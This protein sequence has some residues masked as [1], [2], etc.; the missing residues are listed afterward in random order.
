MGMASN[1]Y[2][3][4]SKNYDDVK[5]GQGYHKKTTNQ[6]IFLI[7]MHTTIQEGGGGGGGEG[8]RRRRRR[9]RNVQELVLGISP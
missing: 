9:V 7:N 6:S 4:P 1:K 8:K 3:F 5:A 2:S